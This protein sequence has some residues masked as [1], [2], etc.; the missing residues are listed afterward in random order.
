MRFVSRSLIGLGTLVA[1]LAA[2]SPPAR[3]QQGQQ[4][5][6]AVVVGN[7]VGNQAERG[8]R[9]AE[10]EVERLA[11]VLQRSGDFASVHV[12]RA[13]TRSTVEQIMK[14]AEKQ[15]SVARAAGKQTLFVF[16]YSGHGD[17]DAL[18][19]GATRLPLRDLRGYL[20]HLPAD[21]RLAFVDACQSGA[22]TGVKGGRRAPAYEVRMADPG[23]VQGM[24]IVTSS[25]ANEL[26]QESDDLRGSYFSHNIMTGLVGAADASGDGQVT[27]SELYNY[28]FRRTLA[29]TAA[30][31]IGGQ[32]PT[33][34]YRMSGTGDVILTRTR[35]K[36]AQLRFPRESGAVYTVFAD[37]DVIAE[38]T[39]SPADD[40]Y[41]A[42]PGGNYRV[43]RRSLARLSERTLALAPGGSVTLEAAAMTPV[44]AMLETSKRKKGGGG[45]WLRNSL[46]AHVGAQSSVVGGT[47]SFLGAVGLA[48]TRDFTALSLRL[49]G[50]IA[51]FDGRTGGAATTYLRVVPALDVLLPL[52][53][54][55]RI[56]FLVG[57]TLGMPMARQRGD[58]ERSR[59]GDETTSSVGFNY[60][61]VATAGVR[62]GDSIWLTLSMSGGGEVFRLNDLRAH[63]PFGTAALG[64]TLGF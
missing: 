51:S 42:L 17:N 45:P 29:S 30:S 13:A 41:L 38:L 64:G 5:R 48:Y 3:A 20:E 53:E 24:A 10:Q 12:L 34:D 43:V 60:G 14:V 55:A 28:A 8:L 9:Y 22:L 40:L 39:S 49:R 18:E 63:R 62:V 47:S 4:V 61:A 6:I 44:L 52:Y 32:H 21:V 7:N 31:L 56:A 54:T 35:P 2:A 46:G 59:S 37:A 27:L 33:Y 36:D 50:D 25:T 19:L 23:N 16:Y 1:V 26:S 58:L 15:L 11:Q 57:P